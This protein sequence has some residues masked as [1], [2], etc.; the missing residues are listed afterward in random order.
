M[1]IVNPV[2]GFVLAISIIP[3]LLPKE[4]VCLASATPFVF[5]RFYLQ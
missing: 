3:T 2:V 5:L 1:I 4:Q